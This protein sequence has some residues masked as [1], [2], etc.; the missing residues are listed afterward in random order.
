MKNF[1]KIK[2]VAEEAWHLIDV[3]LISNVIHDPEGNRNSTI[4]LMGGAELHSSWTVLE[5]A[6]AIHEMQH[7]S[8]SLPEDKKHPKSL[9]VEDMAADLEP[10]VLNKEI[11]D[12]ELESMEMWHKSG[13]LLRDKVLGQVSPERFSAWLYSIFLFEVKMTDPIISNRDWRHLLKDDI[14]QG[15]FVNAVIGERFIELRRYDG[16]KMK[17]RVDFS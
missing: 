14:R 10:P 9:R 17:I 13:E 2:G 4:Y 7:S 15:I 6:E 16:S 1:V 5:I 12:K 8:Q 11:F 3:E